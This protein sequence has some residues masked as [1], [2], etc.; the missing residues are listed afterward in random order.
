MCQSCHIKLIN[1]GNLSFDVYSRKEV[2]NPVEIGTLLGTTI[3]RVMRTCG[4]VREGT[5]LPNP[6]S[7]VLLYYTVV[8][9]IWHMSES[10]SFYTYAIR[11]ILRGV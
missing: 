11:R 10:H 7:P 3:Y 5:C 1:L 2:P 8:C 9:A 6:D 4:E